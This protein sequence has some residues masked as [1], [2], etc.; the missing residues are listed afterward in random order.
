MSDEVRETQAG[1]GEAGGGETGAKLRAATVN[2][3]RNLR[4]KK[5][6][7]LRNPLQK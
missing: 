3:I 5:K 7:R 2:E 6:N 4:L 1:G